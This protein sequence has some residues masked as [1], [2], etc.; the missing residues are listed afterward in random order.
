MRVNTVR[1]I[2]VV[3]LVKIRCDVSRGLD[4]RDRRTAARPED[5]GS[6]G[7]GRVDNPG[8]KAQTRRIR[9]I[10]EEESWHPLR[11]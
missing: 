7:D 2:P 4:K 3:K 6:T 1:G 10:N 8:G 5:G 9:L 11:G